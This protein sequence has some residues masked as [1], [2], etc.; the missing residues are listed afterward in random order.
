LSAAPNS[1]ITELAFEVLNTLA[2]I[3]Y[4]NRRSDL[5]FVLARDR[6]TPARA[7][8]CGILSRIATSY[9]RP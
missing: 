7:T 6:T 8:F 1:S 5:L 4:M 2:V 9:Q 3:R